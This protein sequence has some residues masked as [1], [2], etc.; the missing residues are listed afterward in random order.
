MRHL[1]IM[2]LGKFW[3]HIA[4][5][6][7]FS[8]NLA[9][10][11]IDKTTTEINSKNPIH[12]ISDL[13]VICT[14]SYKNEIYQNIVELFNLFDL[15]IKVKIINPKGI[16]DLTTGI[17]CEQM[18]DL[19][20]RVSMTAY[21]S[22]LFENISYCPAGGRKNMSSDLIQSAHLFGA[23]KIIHI[24]SKNI[25][26]FSPSDLLNNF[27]TIPFHQLEFNVFQENIK[28]SSI[29][30]FVNYP[31]ISELLD[32]RLIVSCVSVNPESNLLKQ[33]QKLN[34]TANDLSFNFYNKM[35]DEQQITNFYALYTLSP[36][37]I[38]QL[39]QSFINE[40]DPDFERKIDL[41]NRLPKCD[42]HFHLGGSANIEEIIEIAKANEIDIKHYLKCN[43]SLKKLIKSIKAHIR[44]N[45]KEQLKEIISS[46]KKYKS[47][48]GVP[49]PITISSIL[50]CFCD[51]QDLLKEL[52]Y[53]KYNYPNQFINI[54]IE[55]FEKLGDLQGSSLLSSKASLKALC[56]IIKKNAEKHHLKYLEVRCSP[57]NYQTDNLSAEE[58]I[59]LLY[60]ELYFDDLCKY[61]LIIIGSR[62]ANNEMLNEHIKLALDSQKKYSDFIVGFD[63]AGNE[64]YGS[65]SEM[66]E[67]FLPLME[68]C[69]HLTIHA[70]ETSSVESIWQA[71]YHLNAE[72]IGHGLYLNK[73]PELYNRFKNSKIAVEMCPTSNY[74]I[75][76]FN[77]IDEPSSHNYNIYPLK[78]YLNN[79]IKVSINT[80]DPGISLSNITQEYIKAIKLTSYELSLWEILK[81]I[82][83]GFKSAF[84]EV[85]QKEKLIKHV[86]TEIIHLV[87]E[88]YES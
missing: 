38:N 69:I 16:N 15:K 59:D 1:M 44:N 40:N 87:K 65:P 74:Q 34:S 5:I 63:L 57:A 47:F 70:G 86:E 13:W 88:Y 82:R 39:H 67:R 61:R 37:L 23:D 66:R 21:V 19:I 18:S 53:S 51:H 48:E 46:I 6:L 41:L 26:N 60:H 75:I 22:G 85:S 54:G 43:Q 3:E 71:V 83:N 11:T 24:L 36:K 56:K 76:G 4:E 68:K 31:I 81:L 33:I 8:N 52:N 42:L 79:N 29:A 77:D 84:L 14:S 28:E 25:I 62:H 58:I 55:E 78:E 2:T 12:K 20:Y 73:K 64:S 27:G 30:F 50:T 32:D 72:R 17:E 80:D 10:H 35:K 49:A 9:I 7:Y 45:E